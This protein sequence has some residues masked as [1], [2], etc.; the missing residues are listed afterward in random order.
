MPELEVD[1][2]NVTDLMQEGPNGAPA[3]EIVLSNSDGELAVAEGDFAFTPDHDVLDRLED[4]IGIS[5][6]DYRF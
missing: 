3:W 5:V 2:N 6:D 1:T 4:G